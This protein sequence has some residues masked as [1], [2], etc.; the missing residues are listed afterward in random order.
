[1]HQVDQEIELVVGDRARRVAIVETVERDKALAAAPKL[2]RHG[3]FELARAKRVRAHRY[4][5]RVV[6]RDDVEHQPTHDVI[7]KIGGEITDVQHAGPTGRR[8]GE[9]RDA[10]PL[11]LAEP[12]VRVMELLQR[13]ARYVEVL[14]LGNRD[15]GE[16]PFAAPVRPIERERQ[17][18]V[19]VL[20]ARGDAGGEKSGGDDTRGELRA[21][22]E[23]SE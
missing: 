15:A 5:R 4:A 16:A 8:G 17:I 23:G 7:A 13:G 1:S 3:V 19:L 21:R 12:V 6:P 9:I 11:L 2:S 10:C 22:L 14:R 18:L 20:R